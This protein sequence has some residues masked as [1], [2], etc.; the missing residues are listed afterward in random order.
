MTNVVPVYPGVVLWQ[1]ERLAV[2]RL[3]GKDEQ[4]LAR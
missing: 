1:R 3:A 2:L 4:E